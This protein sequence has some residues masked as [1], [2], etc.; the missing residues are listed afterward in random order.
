MVVLEGDG[1]EG[2]MICMNSADYQQAICEAGQAARPANGE[3][4]SRRAHHWYRADRYDVAVAA[5]LPM[6]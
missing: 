1:Q 6:R 5:A 3:A 4:V 2:C